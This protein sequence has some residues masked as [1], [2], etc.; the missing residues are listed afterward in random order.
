MLTRDTRPETWRES[1]LAFYP[2][3]PETYRLAQSGTQ[4]YLAA[5]GT[6]FV[7]NMCKTKNSLIVPDTA[8]RCN[9]SSDCATGQGCE[10]PEF[11]AP[12]VVVEPSAAVE[13]TRYWEKVNPKEP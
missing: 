13:W 7:G 9:A 10:T 2:E 4:E 1:D 5:Q 6:E 3:L 11:K 8:L 12:K